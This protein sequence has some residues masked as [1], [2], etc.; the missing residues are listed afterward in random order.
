M[1]LIPSLSTCAAVPTNLSRTWASLSLSV[2]SLYAEQVSTFVQNRESGVVPSYFSGYNHFFL[3]LFDLRF[4]VTE[5]ASEFYCY[6]NKKF[7][8]TYL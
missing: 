6:F 1:A 8:H 2:Q 4:I 3:I 5:S 7:I